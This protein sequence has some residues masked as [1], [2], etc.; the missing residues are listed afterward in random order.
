M[1]QQP[2]LKG[3]DAVRRIA[4]H[5]LENATESRRTLIEEHSAAFRWLLAS[6]L[7][8]NGGG[9]LVLKD[10][11]R[12]SLANAVI[13]ASFFLGGIMFALLTGWFS[14]RANR[15]MIQPLSE[16]IAFWIT[17]AETN[18]FDEGTFKQV[19]ETLT[20][21]LKKARPTQICGWLSAMS[22]LAGSSIMLLSAYEAP[23]SR[24]ETN[25][26][27]VEK[28]APTVRPLDT[29]KARKN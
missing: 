13:A 21:A 18:E 9:V 24:P 19:S 27:T 5:E 11:L 12:F 7:A 15:A 2:P 16:M 22:F 23:S 26:P 10:L 3:A 6:L 14:Q 28:A 25:Q 1:T 17:C 20:P 8:V 4:Q 29:S